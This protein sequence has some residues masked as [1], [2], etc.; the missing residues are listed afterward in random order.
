MGKLESLNPIRKDSR[1]HQGYHKLENP[2]KL[3]G[4]YNAK[5]GVMFRSGLEL[6]FIQLLDL[7]PRCIRWTYESD[8]LIIPYYNPVKKKMCSYYP[9]FYIEMLG[10]SNR[11][12]KYIIEVKSQKDTEKP[13]REKY[14]TKKAYLYQLANSAVVEAKRMASLEYCKNKNMVYVTEEYFKKSN[15]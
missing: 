13:D 9:D 8:E 14:K 2:H 7:S 6:K 11:L 1:F 15:K 5:M 4:T 3:I 12:L 10:N